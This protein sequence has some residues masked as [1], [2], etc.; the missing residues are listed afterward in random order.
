MPGRSRV[1]ARRRAVCD[2]AADDGARGDA[3]EDAGADAAALASGVCGSRR[4]QRSKADAGCGGKADERLM[5]VFSWSDRTGADL[6]LS[7]RSPRGTPTFRGTTCAPSGHF[8][9]ALLQKLSVRR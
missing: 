6:K 3:A 5:H 1:I 4:R 8:G 9:G 2:R 7:R